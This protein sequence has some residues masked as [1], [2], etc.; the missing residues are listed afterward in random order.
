M[1]SL[2]PQGLLKLSSSRYRQSRFGGSV[3][4]GGGARLAESLELE[5]LPHGGIGAGGPGSVLSAAVAFGVTSATRPAL[6]LGSG[7][8]WDVGAQSPAHCEL[9]TSSERM[10]RCR[11]Q[12][13]SGSALTLMEQKSMMGNCDAC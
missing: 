12:A 10:A 2:L 7:A 3:R 8:V 13:P 5:G 1:P 9:S 6:G 4:G 11:A